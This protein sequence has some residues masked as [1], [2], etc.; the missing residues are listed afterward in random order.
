MQYSKVLYCTVQ[1]CTG[2]LYPWIQCCTVLLNVVQLVVYSTV[3]S[4][5]EEPLWR[6]G[7]EEPEKKLTISLGILGVKLHVVWLETI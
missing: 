3:L 1:Y 6:G 7:R 2:Q 4:W 5:G